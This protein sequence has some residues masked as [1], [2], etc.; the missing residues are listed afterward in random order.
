MSE[1]GRWWSVVVGLALVVAATVVPV[2]PAAAQTKADR[3]ACGVGEV[4]GSWIARGPMGQ[5]VGYAVEFAADAMGGTHAFVVEAENEN[6]AVA[7]AWSLPAGGLV[8]GDWQPIASSQLVAVGDFSRRLARAG[9]GEAV[10]VSSQGNIWTSQGRYQP[11]AGKAGTKGD[12]LDLLTEA[13]ADDGKARSAPMSTLAAYRVFPY[14]DPQEMLGEY[15]PGLGPP[16][17]GAEPGQ[18]SERHTSMWTGLFYNRADKVGTMATCNP[19]PEPEKPEEPQEPVV[20]E[21][22]VGPKG[23]TGDAGPKGEPGAKGDVGAQ[24]DKGEAG[25]KGEPG[26]KGDTGTSGPRGPRGAR[27]AK[28]DVGPRGPKGAKGDVGP[29]GPAAIA[30]PPVVE[31]PYTGLACQ[32]DFRSTTTLDSAHDHQ[33][34]RLFTMTFGRQPTQKAV[35]FWSSKRDGGVAHATLADRLMVMAEARPIQELEDREFIS[36]LF[37]QLCRRPTVQGL[38]YWAGVLNRGVSRGALAM[39]MAESQEFLTLTGTSFRHNQKASSNIS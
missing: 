14:F 9:S 25:A 8:S 27:G 10:L 29:P 4:L 36:Y 22:P 31:R 24:G 33:V 5:G 20:T 21:G 2:S 1:L 15:K 18:Q 12:V 32:S 39:Y 11:S 19:G 6:R 3:T 17:A 38:T 26:V 28:G 16:P 35:N 7:S 23:D 37:G 30:P 34:W 13:F